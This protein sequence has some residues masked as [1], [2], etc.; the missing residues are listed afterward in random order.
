M[1]LKLNISSRLTE[2]LACPPALSALVRIA[3]LSK[4]GEVRTEQVLEN[5]HIDTIHHLVL[6]KIITNNEGII[7]IIDKVIEVPKQRKKT[8]DSKL[9]LSEVQEQDLPHRE[10]EYYKVAIAFQRLF[11]YNLQQLGVPIPDYL[12]KARYTKW[13]TATRLLFTKDNC[14]IEDS[15]AVFQY[16]KDHE[17]WAGKILTM[18]KLRAKFSTLLIQIKENERNNKNA[19]GAS[20]TSKDFMQEI[21]TKL[22]T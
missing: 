13:L 4:R 10:V 17:F 11:I 3:L 8:T 19:S 18:D 15:R 20:R 14:T 9:L 6:K 22:A 2:L 5:F 16:L 1:H 21:L 7:T 12:S